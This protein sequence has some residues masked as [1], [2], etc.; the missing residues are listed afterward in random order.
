MALEWAAR[1]A[2]SADRVV[3]ARVVSA[4]RGREQGPDPGVGESS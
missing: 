3:S 1:V 4:T 2:D